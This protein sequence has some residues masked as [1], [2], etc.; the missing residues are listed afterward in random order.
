MR[1]VLKAALVAL[2]VAAALPA[3]A[4]EAKDPARSRGDR[5]FG[6][7][8]G[9]HGERFQRSLGFEQFPNRLRAISQGVR[10]WRPCQNEGCGRER[11][12]FRRELRG[13]R[14]GLLRAKGQ[15]VGE[16]LARELEKGRAGF[17]A[18]FALASKSALGSFDARDAADDHSRISLR[19]ARTARAWSSVKK[20]GRVRPTGIRQKCPRSSFL[21]ATKG[22]SATRP[23][24]RLAGCRSRRPLWHS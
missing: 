2:A 12:E 22:A 24:T 10:N 16:E 7:L 21:K 15:G 4:E 8:P 9:L 17:P 3:F 18:L 14:Q 13:G 1:T 20:V 19:T 23:A 6:R 11:P 5:A